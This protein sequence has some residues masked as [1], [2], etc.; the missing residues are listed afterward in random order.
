[1]HKEPASTT[2]NAVHTT[3]AVSLAF[4]LLSVLLSLFSTRYLINEDFG[5]LV[6]S[7]QLFL[8][9]A[10][11]FMK[12]GYRR[13]AQRS[14]LDLQLAKESILISV[15]AVAIL[16]IAW[17]AFTDIQALD[18]IA[19]SL[20]SCVEATGEVGLY[21][22]L[23][24]NLFAS[25]TVAETI[26]GF[27]RAVLFAGLVFFGFGTLS[28][29]VAQVGYSL[30]WLI[31]MCDY[32][33]IDKAR[34][35]SDRLQGNTPLWRTRECLIFS[36]P[37]LLQSLSVCMQKLV[38]SE[39]EKFLLIGF[40][41]TKVWAIHGLATNFG[42]LIL[43]TLF[44]PL[45]DIAFSTFSIT[46]DDSAFARLLF[47]QGSVGLAAASFGPPVAEQLV[48]L[49]YSRSED[50]LMVEAVRWYCGLLFLFAVNGIVEA[51]F[52]AD[53]KNL[54]K[55]RSLQLLIA[56]AQNVV[57]WALRGNGA[58]GLIVGNGLGMLMR[59]WFCWPCRSQFGPAKLLAGCSIVAGG[60][61]G[62]L[63]RSLGFLGFRGFTATCGVAVMFCL[64]SL[65]L[66][67]RDFP[68]QSRLG[69]G[70][71]SAKVD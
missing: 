7:Q 44:A 60:G 23:S 15:L 67:S 54:E 53:S 26:G 4:K 35:E 21:R 51:K 40:F 58:T 37:S 25:R 48:G 62:W 59:I 29:G 41:P 17:R 31:L 66:I 57:T 6:V 19:L 28:F 71:P 45:E 56:V 22:K 39:T 50:L 65:V 1:M 32:H 49:L 27:V 2:S 10:L 11:F 24:G 70:L 34:G 5:Q 68:E 12:E 61:L 63:L 52:Y 3:I 55:A 9:L 33:E 47:F 13:E 64:P 38:L 14:G 42:S 30:V 36:S 43:R 18:L 16:A 20:A 8:T 69:R 46:Q